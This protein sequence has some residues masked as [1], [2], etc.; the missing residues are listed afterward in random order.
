MEKTPVD[1]LYEESKAAV[2]SLEL[3][4]KAYNYSQLLIL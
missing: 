1:R 4:E 3:N 2:V